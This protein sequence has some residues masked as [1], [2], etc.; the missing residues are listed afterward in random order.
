MLFL[1]FLDTYFEYGTMLIMEATGRNNFRLA[2]SDFNLPV[3][4][5]LFGVKENE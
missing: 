4:S 1:F 5:L 3:G 2:S